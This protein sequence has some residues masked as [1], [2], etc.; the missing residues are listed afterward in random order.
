MIIIVAATPEKA[1]RWARACRLNRKKY[2][3]V[4]SAAGLLQINKHTAEAII[5]EPNKEVERELKC[6]KITIKE[7]LY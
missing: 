7:V 1:N 5:L 2:R 6:L 3:V 4:T